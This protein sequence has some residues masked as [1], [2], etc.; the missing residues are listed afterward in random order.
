MQKGEI[1]PSH[2]ISHR[3]PLA[4]APRGDKIFRDQEEDCI[5]VVLQ[6]GLPKSNSVPER[7]AA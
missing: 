1:D 3:L 5:K 6:P 4:E 7:G 2:I